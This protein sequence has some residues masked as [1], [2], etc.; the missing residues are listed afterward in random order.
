[1]ATIPLNG[2]SLRVRCDGERSRPTVVLSNSLG[3]DLSMWDAQAAVLATRFHVV[4]YDTRGHGGSGAPA[5]PYTIGL[6][7]ADV[8]ALLDHLDIKRAHFVGLSMGGVIG[9]WLGAHAPGRLNKLVLANTASR[10]GTVDGWQARAAAVRTEGT[11]DIAAGAPGRWFTSEFVARQPVVVGTMQKTL[12]SL[13]PEGYAACC[14][15][16]AI[17]DLTADIGCISATTLVIAGTQDPVTTV[18]DAQLLCGTIKG[19]T[20]ATLPASHLS[21][22]EVPDRFSDAVATFLL[23]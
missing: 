20:L 14:E 15:A 16:L 21:N 22:I 23:A 7:G 12:R 6:L 1:M 19:A 11:S 8:L 10:I 4:R 9:Q 13:E 18:A 5:G 2:T 17:A 3:T